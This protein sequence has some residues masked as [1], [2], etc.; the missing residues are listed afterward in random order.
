VNQPGAPLAP[1]GLSATAGNAQ[2]AL[3]WTASS[4]A[5]SYNVLSS[6]TSCGPYTQIATTGGA[7]SN[8]TGL[9]AGATYYYVVQ[10]VNASGTSVNSSQATGVTI[11][12]VPTGL[13]VT[14]ESSSQ[15]NL[16]WNAT[17][18]ATSYRIAQYSNGWVYYT[19]SSPSYSA[20]G[21][22]ANTTYQYQVEAIN[23]SGSSAYCSEVSG[24]TQ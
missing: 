15:I 23:A 4:G 9:T 12:A 16:S 21:L 22:S 17:T 11:P 24:T 20:T 7:S 10:A 18:G 6:T 5:T 8:N 14:P 2:V 13:T 1:T 19:T 3:S